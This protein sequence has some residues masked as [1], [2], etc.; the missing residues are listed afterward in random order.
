METVV[1]DLVKKVS[2]VEY[3]ANC[4]ESLLDRLCQSPELLRLQNKDLNLLRSLVERMA[5]LEARVQENDR[6]ASRI[7]RRIQSTFH[8]VGYALFLLGVWVSLPVLTRLVSLLLVSR[9]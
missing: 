8:A 4:A 2:L 5:A 7:F 3:K 1:S 9:V 6:R